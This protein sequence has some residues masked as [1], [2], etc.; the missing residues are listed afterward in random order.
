M[1]KKLWGMHTAHA[2]VSKQ[3]TQGIGNF[4][5][6]HGSAQSPLSLFGL[7]AAAAASTIAQLKGRV[8]TS[9]D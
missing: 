9:S 5:R 3:P 7:A 8:Q 2:L 4:F 1:G 6:G